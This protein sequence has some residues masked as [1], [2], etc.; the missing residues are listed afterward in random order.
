MIFNC[1]YVWLKDGV[2][3]FDEGTNADSAKKQKNYKNLHN[4]DESKNFGNTKINQNSASNEHYI[5]EKTEN[6]VTDSTKNEKNSV[7]T[8]PK[9][10]V[11]ENNF[12][13]YFPQEVTEVPTKQVLTTTHTT[14]ISHNATIVVVNELLKKLIAN[15]NP[16]F[17]ENLISTNK[18]PTLN[19]NIRSKIKTPKPQK[20]ET[21]SL[22]TDSLSFFVK[23]TSN[24]LL[25]SSNIFGLSSNNNAKLS[26]VSQHSTTYQPAS[27]EGSNNK[28]NQNKREVQNLESF[29]VVSQTGVQ[30]LSKNGTLVIHSGNLSTQASYQC[31]AIGAS[32]V[33]VGEP[34]ILKMACEFQLS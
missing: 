11:I 15:K 20:T 32:G 34:V 2:V 1:R 30:V 9:S 13:K 18:I 5:G 28:S 17:E 8:T 4:I 27:N 14:P 25:K 26:T 10:D 24:I 29:E 6:I 12:Y 16:I 23:D 22:L 3:L 19:Q 33:Y 31:K 21:N 7:M